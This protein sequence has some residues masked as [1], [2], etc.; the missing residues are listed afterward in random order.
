MDAIE[1]LADA[2]RRLTPDELRDR[3]RAIDQEARIIRSL[4]RA[5]LRDGDVRLSH[6]SQRRPEEG[7]P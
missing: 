3:L 4:L 7:R 5:T 2:A 1:Q 6:G